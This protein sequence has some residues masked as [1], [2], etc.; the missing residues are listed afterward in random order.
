MNC[1]RCEHCGATHHW[2]WQEAFDKFGFDDGDGMVMTGTVVAALEA[3]GYA[4]EAAPWGLHNVTITSIKRRG[5]E[6]IP[7]TAKAGYDDPRD[8]LPKA[9]IK[10]LDAAFAADGKEVAPWL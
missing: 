1:S 3:A 7:A 5:R 10:V 8:Y 2:S 9:V 4:V 6:L